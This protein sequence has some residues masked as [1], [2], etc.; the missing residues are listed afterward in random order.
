MPDAFDSKNLK[1]IQQNNLT[2]QRDIGE[3]MGLSGA[4][5]QRG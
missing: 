1:I 4:A 2:S 5:V 3:K